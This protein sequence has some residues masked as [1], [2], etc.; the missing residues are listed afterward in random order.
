MERA[1]HDLLQSQVHFFAVPE[2][3]FLVLHPLEIADRDAARI[4]QD[5]RSTVM[6]RRA[7]DFVG[8]R[9]GW[10]NWRLLRRC[11]P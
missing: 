9:S 3:P 6:P 7:K 4:G 5:V 11:G 1:H 2:Q 8:V 10:T